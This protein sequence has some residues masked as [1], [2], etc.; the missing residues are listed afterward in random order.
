[1]ENIDLGIVECIVGLLRCS[2]I[3]KGR[4]DHAGTTPMH[5]RR[6][7]LIAASKVISELNNYVESENNNSV[8]TTGFM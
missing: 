5:M 8:A 1:M 3:I 4:A 6:D 7:P 2:V